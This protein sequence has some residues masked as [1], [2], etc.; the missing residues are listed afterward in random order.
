MTWGFNI[1]IE[2]QSGSYSGSL[3]SKM[4]SSTLP[5]GGGQPYVPADYTGVDSS[6]GY[7]LKDLAL[8]K[9]E[10]RAVS[11]IHASAAIYFINIEENGIMELM[12]KTG[13]STPISSLANG[14]DFSLS[15]SNI[16]ISTQKTR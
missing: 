8:S 1:K 16:S 7:N 14:G 2:N 13:A 9:T 4:L 15:L 6:Y 3:P 5:S 12:R 11:G 10:L